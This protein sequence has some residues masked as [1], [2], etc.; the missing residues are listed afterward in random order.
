[1]DTQGNA[2]T[3]LAAY[4]EAGGA[5]ISEATWQT[6]DDPYFNW[7]EPSSVSGILGYSYSLDS[8]PD[9][10]I[11]TT[12][13]YYQYPAD[14]LSNGQHTFYVKAKDAAGNWGGYDSFAIWVDDAPPSISSESILPTSVVPGEMITLQASVTDAQSGVQ[15]VWADCSGAWTGTI[16]MSTSCGTNCYE[17]TSAQA[18]P[19]Q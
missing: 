16:T 6:D 9:N 12:N 13:T 10:T 8:V 17:G 15:S 11:D 5:S 2:I 18:F 1:V 14:A 4:T 7:S 3:D 19:V